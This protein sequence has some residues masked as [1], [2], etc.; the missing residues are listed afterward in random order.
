MGETRDLDL[1][2]NPAREEREWIVQRIGWAGMGIA[3][4]TALMGLTGAGPLSKK[5]EGTIGGPIYVEYQ[6]FARYQAASEIKVFCRP[7]AVEE[8]ELT[9]ERGF[10]DR[11]QMDEISPR[12]EEV[13]TLGD[14]YA[15][16]FKRGEGDEHLVTFRMK[17][18]KFG[19]A[20]SRL[21]L[22][23]KEGVEIRPFYWP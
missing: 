23:N 19:R 1:Q 16:R 10:I 4:I 18:E 6:C 11:V 3:V 20:S 8:F 5:H 7:G 2:Y 21:T 12:P 14:R 13:R 15:Y 9:L 17:G 22:D